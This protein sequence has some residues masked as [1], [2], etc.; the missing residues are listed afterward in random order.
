MIFDGANKIIILEAIDGNEVN[1]VDLY[2]RWKDFVLL[3]P[4]WVPAF[5]PVGGDPIDLSAGTSVPLYAFLIN[6]WRLRPRE[7]SHTLSVTGGVLLVDGG[8][9]PFLNTLG[10]FTVRINYQQPVQAIGVSGGG[11]GGA[12]A[13]DIANAVWA[14][15]LDGS[16]T[17][18]ESIRLMNAIL[19]GKVSIAGGS[20]TF[21][22]ANDTK[23]RVVANTDQNG[24]RTSIS[25]DLT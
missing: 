8:G 3:N 23:N 17:A 12:S 24:N 14:L 5:A 19:G 4:Q 15:A 21:R 16:I 6:G 20:V 1:V 9:D 2:S 7:A 18:A 22:D 13:S 25:K 10:V 11:G